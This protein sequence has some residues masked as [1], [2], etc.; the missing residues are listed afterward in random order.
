[1]I[2]SEYDAR[3]YI[4]RNWGAAAL[5]D[6]AFYVAALRQENTLQNLVS[7]A[8][9]DHVWV[10][11]IADSAQLLEHQPE[12]CSSWAD[13]GT[14]AG[15]PGLVIAILRRDLS[16]TLIEPRKLRTAWLERMRES[17]SLGHMRIITGRAEDVHDTFDAVSARAVAPLAAL[18]HKTAHLGHTKSRWLFAKGRTVVEELNDIP[19]SQ[20]RSWLFHVKHSLTA[21]DAS[22]IVCER[23]RGS[24]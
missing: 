2:T 19:A 15:L 16:V 21:P 5:A 18:L 23:S 17:L 1:M 12:N 22:I 13:V 8:S 20:R 7:P 14:G 3:S 4:E 6:C 11:H 24:N 10:R 9:L